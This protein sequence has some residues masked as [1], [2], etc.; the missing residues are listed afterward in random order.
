MDCI[1]SVTVT[2]GRL[3]LTGAHWNSRMGE[4]H[5]PQA[6]E[7]TGNQG[8]HVLHLSGAYLLHGCG[9]STCSTL[10]FDKPIA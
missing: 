3:H 5:L 8:A 2:W 9:M 7:E 10:T 4:L 1:V 6:R